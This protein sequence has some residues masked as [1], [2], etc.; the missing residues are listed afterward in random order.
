MAVD[1]HIEGNNLTLSVQGL[2]KLFS[3]KGSITVPLEHIS[4]VSKA[5][6]MARSE[7]GHLQGEGRPGF[8]GR[9]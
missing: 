6:E 4:S 2:D 3:F 7:I 9:A 8:L 1:V 5:P